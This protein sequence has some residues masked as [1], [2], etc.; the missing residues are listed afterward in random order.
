MVSSPLLKNIMLKWFTLE[1]MDRELMK[2]EMNGDMDKY[3]LALVY[4]ALI[5][6]T[7]FG[8]MEYEA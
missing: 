6:T 3:L 5:V 4:D 1:Y 2:W 7:C 8:W